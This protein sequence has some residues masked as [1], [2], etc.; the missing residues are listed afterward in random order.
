MKYRQLGKTGFSVS[1]IGFG[2]WGIGGATPGPT[3][4]GET[5]DNVSLAALE[6][7]L[8]FGINFFDTSNIYGDGHSEK[9][10]GQAFSHKR[11]QVIIAT[12]AGFVDFKSQPDFTAVA[13]KKSLEQSL[14]RLKTNYVDL[15]QLHNPSA[16]WLRSNPSTLKVLSTFLAEG[17]VKAVGISVK[18]PED[19]IPLLELFPFESIQANF[20]MMDIRIITSGLLKKIADTGIGLI[21]R[22][23]LAFGFL[24]I[25]MTGEEVFDSQDHRSRWSRAQIRAWANGAR[26]LL[27]CCEE[28]QRA[29]AAQ[30]AIRF[31]LSYPQISTT[32]PGMLTPEEVKI[33]SLA[34]TAGVLSPYACEAIEAIHN[35][36]SFLI[37]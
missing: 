29:T 4:Y 26:D 20:N 19:A 27:A 18:Q 23:P 3:S 37:D 17:K 36:R 5:D 25:P 31:C 10:L 13:I 6:A 16:E 33:N 35:E 12:K 7:A 22:T 15:L 30:V 1:E 34:S 8:E 28:S 24:A 11:K 21:A 2:A 32:I 14:D 9:L